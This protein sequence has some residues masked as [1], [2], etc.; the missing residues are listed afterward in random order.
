MNERV[1]GKKRNREHDTG[2]MVYENHKTSMHSNAFIW[3]NIVIS[4][5]VTLKLQNASFILN[6]HEQVLLI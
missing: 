1:Q 3:L 5:K 2:Q 6:L 4:N